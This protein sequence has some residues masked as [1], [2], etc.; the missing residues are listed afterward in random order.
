MTRGIGAGTI[1]N[2][3]AAKYCPPTWAY[4][5]QV[6]NRTGYGRERYADGVAFNLWP[7]QGMEVHGFEVKVDRPD[8]MRE[9]RDPGKAGAIQR[10]CDRWWLVL[11]DEKLIQPGELPPTWG[12]MVVVG[13]KVPKLKS[14]T[15]APKLEPEPLARTFVASVMRNFEQ[16]F[17]AKRVHDDLKRDIERQAKELATQQFQ[18]M[19]NRAD[20]G[21]ASVRIENDNLKAKIQRFEELAGVSITDWDLGNIVHAVQL[22]RNGG[23][24]RVE[25]RLTELRMRAQAILDDVDLGLARIKSDG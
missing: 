12:L 3:L 24:N 14:V 13:D 22:V 19:Q 20:N 18:Q 15:A 5:E 7:S 1:S 6:R 11:A 10:F 8:L 25:Q 23:L 9:L 2:L 17:V 16:N 4:L 21:T